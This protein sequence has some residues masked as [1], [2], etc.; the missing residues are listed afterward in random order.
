MAQEAKQAADDL[1]MG[2]QHLR[3]VEAF[4]TKAREACEAAG[5][6]PMVVKLETVQGAL[7]SACFARLEDVHGDLYELGR[8]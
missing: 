2:L 3:Y 4:I 7:L 5:N 6:A 8:D 1:A